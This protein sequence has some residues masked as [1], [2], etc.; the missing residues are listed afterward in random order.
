MIDG[1]GG[2]EVQGFFDGGPAVVGAVGAVGRDA[3]AHLVVESLGGCDVGAGAGLEKRLGVAA[4]AGA[5][6]AENEGEVGQKGHLFDER[7]R[8]AYRPMWMVLPNGR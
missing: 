6:A 4:L 2:D 8:G 5:G 1:E 7:G 3:G